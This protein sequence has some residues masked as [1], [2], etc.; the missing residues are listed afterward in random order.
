MTR[1]DFQWKLPPAVTHR[2]GAKSYGAQRII[3]EQDHLLLIAHQPPQRKS[4]L[5]QHDVFLRTPDGKWAHNGNPQGAPAFLALIEHYETTLASLEARYAQAENATDVFEI[6]D[7]LLPLTRAAINLKDT[8]Q[9]ARDTITQDPLLIE[10]RDRSSETARGLEL[11]L[12]NAKVAMDYQL[13][14]QAEA[15]TKATTQAAAAQT[16]LNVLA[17]LTLPLMTLATVFGM[18]LLSGFEQSLGGRA[19]WVVLAAGLVLGYAVRVWVSTAA[20]KPEPAAEKSKKATRL[21]TK[22]L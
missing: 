8:L 22:K 7:R 11:L 6:M 4:N 5:R 10:L 3:F 20:A 1:P 17:A 16:K 13:A 21:G 19:F 2:L 15:Q 14:R 18:N 9:A 12:A